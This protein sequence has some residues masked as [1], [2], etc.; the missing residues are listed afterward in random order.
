MSNYKSLKQDLKKAHK[1]QYGKKR[2][3]K[4][5]N[6]LKSLVDR[7]YTSMLYS[8]LPASHN[9]IKDRNHL[10]RK[11]SR[12]QLE[13]NKGAKEIKSLTK[14]LEECNILYKGKA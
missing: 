3:M 14:Q 6:N 4:I 7:Q 13:L 9:L 2:R 12:I 11:I 10:H 1:L 5:Y 8:R